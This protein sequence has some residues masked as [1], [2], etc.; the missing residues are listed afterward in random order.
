MKEAGQFITSAGD[1]LGFATTYGC[2]GVGLALA[3][4]VVIRQLY[5]SK[6]SPDSTRCFVRGIVMSSFVGIFVALAMTL[7]GWLAFGIAQS[8]V[9]GTVHIHPLWASSLSKMSSKAGAVVALIALLF[10]VIGAGYAFT[11]IDLSGFWHFLAYSAGV[12]LPEETAKGLAGMMIVLWVA[13]SWGRLDQKISGRKHCALF[14]GCFAIAGLGFGTGEALKYF[15]FYARQDSG[16]VWYVV[17]ALWCIPLHGVWSMVTGLIV[18]LALEGRS[19]AQLSGVAEGASPDTLTKITDCLARFGLIV[20]MASIP[21]ALLHGLY[22]AAA[23]HD[24]ILMWFLG[25]ACLWGGVKLVSYVLQDMPTGEGV[26]GV[27]HHV[28]SSE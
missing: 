3:G 13:R 8:L 20:L 24:S 28:P 26:A 11:A 27:E 14:V 9:S 5:L 7:L 22:D 6:L 25:L 19:Y 21:A 12:G 16:L 17:R 15:G 18:Y 10:L 1:F 2:I 23:W 4:L